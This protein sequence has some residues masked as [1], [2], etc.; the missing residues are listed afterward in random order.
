MLRLQPGIG[1]AE[2]LRLDLDLY[3]AS[4]DL[5]QSRHALGDGKVPRGDA[6]GGKWDLS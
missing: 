5:T 6:R 2:A 3:L 4:D 1:R